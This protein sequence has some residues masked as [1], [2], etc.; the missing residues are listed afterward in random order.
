MLF[1]KHVVPCLAQ[2]VPAA[3]L[4]GEVR[5]GEQETVRTKQ[6]STLEASAMLYICAELN[7]MTLTELNN[8]TDIP[9]P[10]RQFSPQILSHITRDCSLE[11]RIANRSQIGL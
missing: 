10:L 1:A 6:G 7:K 3:A 8:H 9:L 5:A 4:P 11:M 2:R